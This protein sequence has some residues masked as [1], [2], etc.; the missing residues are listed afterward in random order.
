MIISKNPDLVVL[1]YPTAGNAGKELIKFIQTHL[2]ETTLVLVSES[3][4]YALA[5]I[6]MGIYN[7]LLKPLKQEDLENIAENVKQIKNSNNKSRI[8]K[9][10][11]QTSEDK[12]LRLQTIRGYIILDPEEIL[13]C[14]A[15]GFYTEIFLTDNRKELSYLFISKLDEILKQ[16]NFMRVSRSYLVN[17]KFIRKI[18][19]SNNTIVLTSN[20][21]EYE[22]KSSKQN[23]RILS[24]ITSE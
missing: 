6:R 3:K 18:Y 14:K 24:K 23:I 12:R 9:L 5:A 8:G 2:E 11:E 21:Q 4:K 17:L 15:D 20:G 1:E 19:K 13:Y 10:I 22:V 7:Y 16:F